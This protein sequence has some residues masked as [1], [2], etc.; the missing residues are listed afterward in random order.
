MASILEESGLLESTDVAVF[1][2]AV[3]ET[4]LADPVLRD[5]PH[6]I[7]TDRYGQIIRSPPP[8]QDH[9]FEQSQIVMKLGALLPHGR[10]ITECPLSTRE[11]VK[12]VDVAWFSKPKWQPQREQVCLT[13]APEICV[14]VV[15]PG[16]SQR[17][18]RE[19]KALYF[20]AGAQEVWFCQRDGSMEFFQQDTPEVDGESRLG[21]DFPRRIHL[22]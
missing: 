22:E 5:L 11:G 3:W 17:E 20:P 21:P 4:V 2:L 18:L 13:H 16:N 19:K 9:G 10:V 14:E 12:G 6:R 15:S 1:N 8:S 7:E